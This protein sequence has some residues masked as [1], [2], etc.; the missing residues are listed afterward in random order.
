[1]IC[2]ASSKVMFSYSW[3][4]HSTWNQSVF[5][6]CHKADVLQSESVC[7]SSW[8]P[9]RATIVQTDIYIGRKISWVQF[10]QTTKTEKAGTL[11]FY[12]YH[13]K[14]SL[15]LSLSLLPLSFLNPIKPFISLNQSLQPRYLTACIHSELP[16]AGESGHFPNLLPSYTP[17]ESNWMEIDVSVM[18]IQVS[19]CIKDCSGG[20]FQP[21]DPVR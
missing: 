10:N 21:A 20:D 9:Q 18:V 2:A 16:S 8:T 15:S 19:V 7:V 17:Q 11:H 12:L 13:L 14:L 4:Q 1:M 6:W 3:L 5:S